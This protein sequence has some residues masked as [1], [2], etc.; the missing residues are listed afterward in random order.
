[1]TIASKARAKVGK[2]S[3][4]VSGAGAKG[5]ARA[6]PAGAAAPQKPA[7]PQ[8]PDVSPEASRAAPAALIQQAYRDLM[9]GLVDTDRGAEAGRTY[10]RLKA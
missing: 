8:Q 6:T 10:K 1:M 7:L 3:R 4:P 2:P 9:Q 5:A